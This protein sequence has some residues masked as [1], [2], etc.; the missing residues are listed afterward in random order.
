LIKYKDRA[1]T[2]SEIEEVEKII[3]N[4]NTRRPWEDRWIFSKANSSPH[5]ITDAWIAGY[6]EGDG[7]FQYYLPDYLATIQVSQ[8][9]H[10]RPLLEAIR[11]YLGSG[12]LKPAYPKKCWSTC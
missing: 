11:D 7:S 5:K 8:S 9:N 3:K 12:Y 6:I 10:D 2:R 1:P 4:M